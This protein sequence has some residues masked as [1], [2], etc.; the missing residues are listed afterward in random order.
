[1]VRNA[2]ASLEY[3]LMIALA[4]IIGAII[5]SQ[6]IGVKGYAKKAGETISAVNSRIS[7][8]LSTIQENGT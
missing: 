7:S 3:L 2:Q 6:L 8:E 1:M 4:L 5:I